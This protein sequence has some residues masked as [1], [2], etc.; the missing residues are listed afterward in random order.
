M[1]QRIPT[2]LFRTIMILLAIIIWFAYFVYPA[3]LFNNHAEG[4][5]T[6]GAVAA[7]AVN[8]PEPA[9]G[10]E[11]LSKENDLSKC[12][13]DD[14]Q[15]MGFANHKAQQFRDGQIKNSHGFIFPAVFRQ[16]ADNAFVNWWQAHHKSKCC[17]P[18]PVKQWWHDTTTKVRCEMSS[19][20]NGT[21]CIAPTEG[22]AQLKEMRQMAV[23]T[24]KVTVGCGAT[25][26]AASVEQSGLPNAFT[27]GRG[28]GVCMFGVLYWQQV[29]GHKMSLAGEPTV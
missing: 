6:E 24:T 28:F 9:V 3:P 5:V 2:W 12:P 18:D 10:A 8:D 27:I 26:L 25:A 1:I 17:V 4:A 13:T 23:Y 11:D 29:L 16:K 14:Q 19:A 7:A 22:S 20:V 21:Q 15:C